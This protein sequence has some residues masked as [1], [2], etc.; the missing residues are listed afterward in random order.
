LSRA[1]VLEQ[2]V[3][4][5]VNVLDSRVWNNKNCWHFFLLP[6]S[7]GSGRLFKHNLSP[8][9]ILFDQ[10]YNKCQKSVVNFYFN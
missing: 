2:P 4:V 1:K 3:K 9:K 10:A 8:E 6:T 7:V 5:I